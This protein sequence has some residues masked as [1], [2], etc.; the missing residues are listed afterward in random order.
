M[1]TYSFQDVVMTLAGPGG[2][3]SL[4]YGNAVAEE[5]ISIEPIEDKNTLTIGAD[6]EGMHSLHSSNAKKFTL[7]LLKTSPQN[8]LIQAM[9]NTQKTSAAL[10]G[11]NMIVVRQTAS[12]DTHTGVDG[13]FVKVAP[14]G[15]KKVG[16]FLEWAWDCI[17]GESELGKY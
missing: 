6:G 15:Y 13:A 2:V 14:N 12:G 3:L 8:Q 7:R 16:D 9:Y 17:K 11:L 1:S 5:G 4:G 10:W